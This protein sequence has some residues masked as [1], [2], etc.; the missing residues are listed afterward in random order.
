[1][2]IIQLQEEEQRRE[3]KGFRKVVTHAV[4]LFYVIFIM[5]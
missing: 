4:M 3:G 5:V 2:V 1:M